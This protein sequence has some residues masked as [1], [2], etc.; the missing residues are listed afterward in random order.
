MHVCMY[1]CMYCVVSV[2][3]LRNRLLGDKA[4]QNT[5]EKRCSKR[6]RK[7]LGSE[8][9]PHKNY[10]SQCVIT[11]PC[12]TPLWRGKHCNVHSYIHTKIFVHYLHKLV[13]ISPGCRETTAICAYLEFC[14]FLANPFAKR[15]LAAL[16]CA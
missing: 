15:M 13:C 2:E 6:K 7:K 11:A 10:S 14:S 5:I 4:T 1:V 16:L 12:S 9:G 8:Y 3:N